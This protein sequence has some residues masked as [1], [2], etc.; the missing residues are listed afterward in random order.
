VFAMW[1][2]VYKKVVAKAKATDPT[3]TDAKIFTFDGL[4]K[5]NQ[6]EAADGTFTTFFTTNPAESN[7]GFTSLLLMA[8]EFTNA[9]RGGIDPASVSPRGQSFWP[10]VKQLY[11]AP[12]GRSLK[13]Y[14]VDSTGTLFRDKFLTSGPQSEISGIVTYENLAIQYAEFA[15]KTHNSTYRVVYPARNVMADN[16]YYVLNAVY[17]SATRKLVL[18]PEKEKKAAIAFMQFLLERE[19]QNDAVILGFRP[20]NLQAG[21]DIAHETSPFVTMQEFGIQINPANVR[22]ISTTAVGEQVI[23]NLLTGWAATAATLN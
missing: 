20:G 7:S 23:Q 6:S 1:D 11:T 16:P 10:H 21:I 3:V 9:G 4:I 13:N 12:D 15:R 17:D 2:D 8:H 18:T 22:F 19:Q 5:A 14:T